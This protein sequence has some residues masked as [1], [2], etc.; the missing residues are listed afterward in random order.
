MTEQETGRTGREETPQ[1]RERFEQYREQI[2]QELPE[3]RQRAKQIEAAK[4]EVAMREPTISGQL[5][6]AVAESRCD[7]R[8][9]AQNVG[10][11]G[12]AMAEFLIGTASLDSSTIDKLAELLKQELKP[13]D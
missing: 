6:R 9:L 3:L 4:R 12:K 2:E 1:E 8:E 13:I 11:S 10:V 5:R 7:C